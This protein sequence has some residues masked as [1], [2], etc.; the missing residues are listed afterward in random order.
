[1]TG[2][3]PSDEDAATTKEY[4]QLNLN[5]G[6]S[7][8]TVVL[9]LG[10]M[11]WLFTIRGDVGSHEQRLIVVESAMREMR[12]AQALSD[13]KLE[14]RLTRIEVLLQQVLANLVQ[15]DRRPAQGP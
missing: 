5:T 13:V 8:A 1:M 3:L 12:T 11:A 9:V 4:P 14:G 2:H 10:G 7:L 15:S 6:M